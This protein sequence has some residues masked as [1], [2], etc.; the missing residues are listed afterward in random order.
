MS[1]QQPVVF[2]VDGNPE[3][4][5]EL[6]QRMCSKG[7]ASQRHESAEDFL[8][9][10]DLN[11]P[12]CVVAALCLPGSNGLEFQKNLLARE[13]RIPLILL[14]PSPQ[15]D[16]TVEAI[17][18]G[19]VTVLETPCRD[20]ELCSAVRQAL[21]LDAETRSRQDHV[22]LARNR[23]ARLTRREQ[24]VLGLVVAGVP[25]KGIA[26]RLGISL[27]TVEYRRHRIFEKTATGSLADLIRLE[28]VAAMRDDAHVPPPE[29][30]VR[31]FS[32]AR[33]AV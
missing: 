5:S 10:Y 11:Q 24:E 18:N 20:D 29:S 8:Q 4:G 12:G 17:R 21:A 13:I 30:T 22:H 19:A 27:R 32:P 9:T 31:L 6:S 25:N 16:V 7:F 1:K 15:T 33:D 28:F 14:I 2:V 23:I 26:S 3:Q